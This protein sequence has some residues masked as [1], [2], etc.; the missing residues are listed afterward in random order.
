MNTTNS[1]TLKLCYSVIMALG[2]ESKA[3]N[4]GWKCHP[5]TQTGKC[6][7]FTLW[8][9]PEGPYF[10]TNTNHF[11]IQL[12]LHLYNFFLQS[13]FHRKA[14]F[15]PLEK[16]VGVHYPDREKFLKGVW[17]NYANEICLMLPFRFTPVFLSLWFWIYVLMLISNPGCIACF[18][19]IQQ[20]MW[21]G[22]CIFHC[23]FI[24]D[25]CTFCNYC[26]K[27]VCCRQRS[28]ILEESGFK[29]P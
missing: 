19:P 8:L 14:L 21:G 23:F 24:E 18:V 10:C 9:R 16:K 6:F 27:W 13:Y 2:V 11:H 7:V 5:Q 17:C 25:W 3:N 15:L 1:L 22:R 28:T 12:L 4:V 20:F 29:N 26:N